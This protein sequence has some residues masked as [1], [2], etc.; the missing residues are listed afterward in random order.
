MV[1]IQTL[2][3]SLKLISYHSTW[4]GKFSANVISLFQLQML[5]I[6]VTKLQPSLLTS[7]SSVATVEYP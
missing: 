3:F 6:S 1:K 2:I 4:G 7:L 5:Q